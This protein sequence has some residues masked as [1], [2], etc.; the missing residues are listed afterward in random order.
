[1][2]CMIKRESI[3]NLAETHRDDLDP[4]AN[5]ALYLGQRK[6]PQ[7]SRGRKTEWLSDPD[8]PGV[9]NHFTNR[10]FKLSDRLYVF[11][12]FLSRLTEI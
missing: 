10:R 8:D 9:W 5:N 6:L 12:F 1:M 7:D 4:H 11:S 2:R 3:T